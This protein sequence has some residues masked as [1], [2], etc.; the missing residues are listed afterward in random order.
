MRLARQRGDITAVAEE[1]QRLLA[2]AMTAGS[3]LPALGEDLRALAL[4][5]LGIAELW[6]ARFDEASRTS[7][8]AS[9]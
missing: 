1:A 9:R 3:V 4:I 7:S 6:T 2:P 8:T 5:N